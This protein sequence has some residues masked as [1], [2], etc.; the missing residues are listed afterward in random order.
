MF[1]SRV[2]AALALVALTSCQP[3]DSALRVTIEVRPQGTALVFADCL[4]LRVLNPAGEELLATVFPRPDDNEAIVAVKR[5]SN[6]PASIQLQVSGLIGNCQ[7]EDSLKLNTRSEPETFTFP[8]SGVADASLTLGPPDQSLDRDRDGYASATEGGPDCNDMVRTIFPGAM[9]TCSMHDVDTDCDGTAGCDDAECNGAPVCANPPTKLVMTPPATP[10]LDALD[11]HGCYGPFTFQLQNESGARIAVRE[12]PLTLAPGLAGLTFHDA[13]NCMS[14]AVTSYRI[15]YGTDSVQLYMKTDGVARGVA[16]VV[17]T[18]ARVATPATYQVRVRALPATQLVVTSPDVVTPAGACSAQTIDFELRDA[19]GR[20]TDA[21]DSTITVPLSVTRGSDPVANML[22][23]DGACGTGVSNLSF[24]PGVGVASVHVLNTRAASYTVRAAASPFDATDVAVITAASPSRLLRDSPSY[25]LSPAVCL[26][27]GIRV[28]LVDAFDNPASA[29]A[30]ATLTI[31]P[32]APIGD[33]TF[34]EHPDCQSNAT[35]T[36]PFGDAGTIYAR[37]D[38][39]AVGSA[40]IS[41]DIPNVQATEPFIISVGAG[42]PSRVDFG[43]TGQTILAG[44]CSTMGF[45]LQLQDNVGNPT[46]A[47][48]GG[49]PVTLT[50][51]TG[52]IPSDDLRFFTD[53]SC[54]PDAGRPN[55]VIPAGRPGV[56]VYFGGTRARPSF[57]FAGTSALPVMGDVPGNVINPQAPEDLFVTPA[58]ASAL[59]GGCAGYTAELRDTFGNLTSFSTT[60]ALSLQNATHLNL[61]P[62]GTCTPGPVSIAANSNNASFFVG[63]TDAGTYNFQ[64]RVDTLV[65]PVTLVVDA[66]APTLVMT[67]ASASTTAGTCVDFQLRRQDLYG[68]PTP[69][70]APTPLNFPVA[71]APGTLVFRQ[72][73]CTGTVDAGVNITVGGSVQNFSVRPHVAGAQTVAVSG[74]PTSSLTVS[75]GPVARVALDAGSAPLVLSAGACSPAITAERFDGFGNPVT[76]GAASLSIGS[77]GLVSVFTDSSCVTPPGVDQPSIN[78]GASRSSNFYVSGTVADAGTLSAFLGVLRGDLPVVVGA[79]TPSR[80]VFTNAPA[81]A[82]AG[83]CAGPLT[84]E[85]RD[86]YGNR[87]TPAGSVVVS[88]AADAGAGLDAGAG[89]FTAAGCGTGATAVTLSSAAPSGSMHFNTGRA[90]PTNFVASSPGLTSAQQVW[91]INPGLLATLAWR[92]PPPATLDRFGCVELGQVEARDNRG[93]LVTQAS[94]LALTQYFD[95]NLAATFHN[96]SAC[97]QPPPASIP[98]GAAVSN[99]FFVAANGSDA[100]VIRVQASG[101]QTPDALVTVT[102]NQGAL[103]I[104]LDA[105][106]VEAGACLPLTVSRFNGSGMLVT[107]GGSSFTLSSSDPAIGI[108]GGANCAGAGTPVSGSFSAGASTATPLY[109]KGRSSDGGVAVTLTATATYG[110]ADSGTASVSPLPLVRRGRCD[111]LDTDGVSPGNEVR[112]ELSPPIPDNDV[113][114]SFLLFSSTGGDNTASNTNVACRLDSTGDAAVVCGRTGTG[115]GPEDTSLLIEYQVVS[116]G[117]GLDAGG[118]SVQ[119]LSSVTDSSGDQLVPITAVPLTESFVLVSSYGVGSENGADDFLTANLEAGGVRL[120]AGTNKNY[121][122]QVVSFSGANV[123]RGVSTIDA[124]A[125]S[126]TLAFPSAVA[127]RTFALFSVNGPDATDGGISDMCRRRVRGVALANGDVTFSRG[128]GAAACAQ[129]PVELRWEV[130]TLPASAGVQ[131]VDGATGVSI[132]GSSTGTDGFLTTTP[133]F[134][135]QVVTHRAVAFFGTQGPGG[136]TAGESNWYEHAMNNGDR[137]DRFHA[138]LRLVGAG[139]L[140]LQC[141]NPG[142]GN[143]STFSPV[144]VQFEP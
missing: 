64:A 70:P 11:R 42:A 38:M 23:S 67:P 25:A 21:E 141:R 16:N 118:V 125:S 119:H 85:L 35:N 121:S 47:P 107:R 36:V 33:V 98:M 105:G 76:T 74:G 57:T 3:P 62:N 72:A 102:G 75:P 122:V 138:L 127:G 123:T 129:D 31:T 97:A 136:Q 80:V 95:V 86:Q 6:L 65:A 60:R 82:T 2:L 18:A 92:T 140:E 69:V 132:T 44:G 17:V 52:S 103:V 120:K 27:G 109:I 40:V 51:S 20:R 19:Q 106:V 83:A 24:A 54:D 12:T 5:G 61:A 63:S 100:G 130:V 15:A 93:N 58:S 55:V 7:N 30:N 48:D 89:F 116:Y 29:P 142:N 131:N 110:G 91:T 126:L 79:A 137:T 9:Q 66:G 117:R 73:A 71:T 32:A 108:Y 77:G 26:P 104:N 4:K 88:F 84:V 78:N 112:C 94:P 124:G 143:A 128:K 41:T 37:G 53:P 113:T 144:V 96:D 99:S 114:R 28:S 1:R 10:A 90:E 135:G 8:E 34:H 56:T 22:F 87:A 39:V 59:A 81:T 111:L 46:N 49:F 43:G 50:A 14:S 115:S 134:S 68:N 13:S 133:T 101:A 45:P 139:S